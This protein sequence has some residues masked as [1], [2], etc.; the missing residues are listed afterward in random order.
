[1]DPYNTPIS[2]I[3]DDIPKMTFDSVSAPPADTAHTRKQVRFKDDTIGLED[4]SSKRSSVSGS[5]SIKNAMKKLRSSSLKSIFL[6]SKSTP[7]TPRSRN[8]KLCTVGLCSWIC[9]QN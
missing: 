2:I 8:L 3:A 5:N 4:H 9:T 1:M 7:S 6:S